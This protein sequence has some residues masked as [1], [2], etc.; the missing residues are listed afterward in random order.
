M[1]LSLVQQ[2][3]IVQQEFAKLLMLGSDGRIEVAAP[4]TDDERRDYVIHVPES[5]TQN[6]LTVVYTAGAVPTM[7][8][9]AMSGGSPVGDGAFLVTR[10]S[11][12]PGAHTLA[13]SSPFGVKV[14]GLGNHTSYLYPGGLDLRPIVSVIHR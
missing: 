1:P 8:G 3:L 5:Y 14:S 7:D 6:F 13:S 9:T 10:F 4:L 2:G 12:A 11:V